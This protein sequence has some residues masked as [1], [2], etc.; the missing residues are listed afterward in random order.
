M[1]RLAQLTRSLALVGIIGL[2]AMLAPRPA[3]QAASTAPV[4]TAATQIL[5][6]AKG[7]TLYIYSPDK[8]NSSVCTGPCAKYWPPVMLPAG[9]TVPM[10]VSGIVG[11]FGVAPR[12]GGT[13]QLTFDGA[14]L[15]TWIKDKKTGDTTGQG[16]EGIWWTVVVATSKA[17]TATTPATGP[18]MVKTVPAKMLVTPKGMALYLY[19]PDKPTQSACS[20]GCAKYWPPLD[21]AAGASAPVALTG[22]A[23]KFATLART[24]GSSQL[25]Y[26]G[27]PL[28]TWIKDKKPGDITGQG[29]EGIWWV[30]TI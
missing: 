29:V 22:I 23:G 14:P 9:A 16:V 4:K 3:V 1:P 17:V 27:A 24:D 6:N 5:A 20:G 10:T 30:V 15:Y 13:R 12:A 19:T 25:S 18:A 21:L 2:G 8:H 26:D 11:T 7:M 28:Y